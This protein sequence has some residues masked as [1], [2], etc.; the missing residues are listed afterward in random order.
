MFGLCVSPVVNVIEARNS[1][2]P[3][4]SEV[5]HSLGKGEVDSSILSMGTTHVVTQ[6]SWRTTHVVTKLLAQQLLCFC[7]YA[8]KFL[9][10]FEGYWK[11]LRKNLSGPSRTL[12]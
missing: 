6:L 12:T 4:S 9:C 10:I 5:E 1:E 2:R 8:L 11:W 7:V 3:C